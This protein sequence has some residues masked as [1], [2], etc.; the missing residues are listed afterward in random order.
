MRPTPYTEME[1]KG[2]PT[3]SPPTPPPPHP[4]PTPPPRVKPSVSYSKFS[5]VPGKGGLQ[6]AKLWE[7]GN[8]VSGPSSFQTTYVAFSK[9][10]WQSVLEA[11]SH[12]AQAITLATAAVLRLTLCPQPERTSAG[13]Q[14]P[15]AHLSSQI[16]PV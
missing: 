16:Q 12:P 13:Y 4:P 9:S 3:P 2:P 14:K 7:P 10:L 15:K 1:F 6:G 8:V 11:I 5:V